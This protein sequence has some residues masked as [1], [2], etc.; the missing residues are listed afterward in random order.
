MPIRI[1]DHHRSPLTPLLFL[2]DRRHIDDDA[3]R[4]EVRGP[5][6]RR[7]RAAQSHFVTQKFEV[8]RYVAED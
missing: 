4:P 6:I 2:D 1:V 7:H 3:R 8:W 5:R